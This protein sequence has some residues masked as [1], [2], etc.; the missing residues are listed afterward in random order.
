M[1]K[2]DDNKC[3]DGSTK[4]NVSIQKGVSL[5]K[6]DESKMNPKIDDDVRPLTIGDSVIRIID[7]V[8][9][10]NVPKADSDAAMG[11]YQSVGIQKA[12]EIA[13]KAINRV[14]TMMD[15]NDDSSCCR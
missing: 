1:G 10:A 2:E 5:G 4:N 7:R 15:L 3:H 9:H 13:N 14:K 12:A 6:P 11:R 8:A